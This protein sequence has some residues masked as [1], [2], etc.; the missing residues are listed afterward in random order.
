MSNVFEKETENY[1]LDIP[2]EKRYLH[3]IPYDYSVQYL[4]E[5]INRGKI[6]LEVPFQRK[7]VWKNDKASALIESI[8]MN[9]PIPPLY[10]AEEDDGKWLVL[11]GLQRLSSINNFYNNEFGLSKLDVLSDLNS[12]KYKDLPPKSKDLLDDGMLRVNVIKN[13]SHRDIKYDIFMRLNRGAVT[14]NYQ[15]LRNCMYRGNLNDAAKE[16]CSEN[17]DFLKILK[18]KAPHPRYLDAEFIIRYFAISDNIAIDDE[19]KVYLNNYKGK[20]VQFLNEYMDVHKNCSLE[21]KEAFK[22]RFNETIRKV[23]LVFGTDKAFRDISSKNTK[24][25]KTIAD[26]IMPSFERMSMSYIEENKE[27][28]YDKLQQYLNY[29]E[30]KDA[31]S[32]KTSDKDVVN[33]RIRMWFEELADAISIWSHKWLSN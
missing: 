28:I 16:L 29:D 26:F 19:G 5:L 13:D 12:L 2:K 31:I 9:V 15:E 24:I 32:T 18:Q 10:F 20:L 21:E 1:E 22:N 27:L 30:I 33:L 14:L 3:S 6:V 4:N 11:D 23:V 25:Y 8:I 7:Q 17:T